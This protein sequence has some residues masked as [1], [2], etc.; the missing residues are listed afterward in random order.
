MNKKYHFTDRETIKELENFTQS[1]NLSPGTK[2]RYN[3]Y[4]GLFLTWLHKEQ[5]PPATTRTIDILAFIDE[6]RKTTSREVQHR[7]L[8]I[9]RQ[10]FDYKE[11]PHNPVTGIRLRGG[12][13]K[14]PHDLLERKTLDKLYKN[15]PLITVN[16]YRDKVITGLVVFQALSSG[17]LHHLQ[18]TD[19]DLLQGN[20]HVPGHQ[21]VNGRALPLEGFQVLGLHEY[22]QTIRPQLLGGANST[23]LL[24]SSRGNENIKNTLYK[25]VKKL[26]S[27][28]GEIKDI[29]QL[30]RSV[31]TEWL[32]TKDLRTVQ[33]LAGHKR[34]SSTERYQI[35]N[36][37]DL[38]KQLN[39]FHPLG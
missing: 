17:D 6:I 34:V 39:Q 22:I 2:K 1:L 32:K 23:Q 26:K 21:Q 16:D 27:M 36:V 37:E 5:I 11:H 8:H 15:H 18:T 24:I 12:K 13:R 30:R 14:P 19:I 7:I 29:S 20:I 10:Y 25:V 38:K 31:I 33:Y 4:L 3:N 9:L 35:V 28:N